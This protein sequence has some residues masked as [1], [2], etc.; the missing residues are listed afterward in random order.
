MIVVICN[1][2]PDAVRGKI[3]LWFLEPKPNVFISGIKDSLADR[4]VDLLM[5]KSF[6]SSG[7]LIFKSMKDAPFFKIYTR[8]MP[9]KML[10]NISGLQLMIEK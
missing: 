5:E 6:F 7:M 3:K 4:V 2:L 9:S 1:D 10:T 8:G